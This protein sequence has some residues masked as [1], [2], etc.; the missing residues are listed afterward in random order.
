[1]LKKDMIAYVAQLEEK[2][3]QLEKELMMVGQQDTEQ[4]Q[5]RNDELV[6]EVFDKNKIIDNLNKTIDK[7]KKVEENHGVAL[8]EKINE[9]NEEN[10]LKTENVRNTY[11]EAII[12]L[13]KKHN[14]RLDEMKQGYE[15][16]QK[17]YNELAQLF[18]EYIRASDDIIELGKLMVRNNLRSQELM[19]EKIK[20]FNSHEGGNKE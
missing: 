17:K 13:E 2:V 14:I 8:N 6:Q 3:Q 9:I 20:K 16:L 5:K 15:V 10:K 1:M 11:K 12:D 18:D 4:L 7:Q 19:N